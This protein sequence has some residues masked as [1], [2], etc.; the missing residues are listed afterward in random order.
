ML[1]P[2]L[3]LNLPAY[4]ECLL[5]D[6]TSGLL[7]L[8]NACIFLKRTFAYCLRF[9]LL[10]MAG[11][12]FCNSSKIASSLLTML[13]V[14]RNLWVISQ[15]TRREKPSILLQNKRWP[16]T[17][18]RLYTYVVK[19]EATVVI[20]IPNFLP[21]CFRR[22]CFDLLSLFCFQYCSDLLLLN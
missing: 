10:F 8:A 3:E 13:E 12:A 2:T 7:R 18:L 19:N 9:G 15:A 11:P 4:S 14:R 16:T 1:L 17:L 6:S 5:A 20:V 21:L 22:V